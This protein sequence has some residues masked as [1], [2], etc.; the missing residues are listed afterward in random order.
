MYRQIQGLQF[1]H[2]MGPYVHGFQTSQSLWVS[3]TVDFSVTILVR[4]EDERA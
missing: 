1:S 2:H 4:A 3:V